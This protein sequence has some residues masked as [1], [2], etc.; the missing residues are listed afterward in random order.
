MARAVAFRRVFLTLRR[1]FNAL[2]G[3]F[4]KAI[5]TPEVSGGN[6]FDEIGQSLHVSRSRRL[7]PVVL[8]LVM[9]AAV[10]HASWNAVLRDGS[11]RLWSMTLMMIAVMCVSAAALAFVPLPKSAS[12]PYVMASAAIHSGYN[13]SLVR[14]Y[15]SGDLGQTYPVSRGSSP[16]LVTMG[17]AIS[18]HEAITVIS[19]VGIAMVSLGILSLAFQGKNVRSDFLLPAFATGVLIGAYTVVDGIGVRLSGSSVGYTTSMFLLWSIT[20]P[21][22][23]FAMRGKPSA[24]TKTQTA[25]ALIGGIV[26]ILAYGIV[27]WAMQYGAMGVVSALRETSVVYAAV[28]GWIFLNE[29]LSLRRILSCLAIAAGAAC[30]AL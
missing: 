12:W 1:S 7:T 23:Y 5:L 9:C 18:A 19:A 28:I 29:K 26:S 2:K 25:M 3:K 14:T 6:P 4:T 15:R 22:I 16:V 21:A 20:M 10:L 24:Y 11:D 30:L 8:G 27:I 17:A 13:L